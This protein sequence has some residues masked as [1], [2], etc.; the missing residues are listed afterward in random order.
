MTQIKNKHGKIVINL[1]YQDGQMA[2]LLTVM[3]DELS[4]YV[5]AKVG[6]PTSLDDPRRQDISTFYGDNAGEQAQGALGT[7]CVGAEAFQNGLKG[8]DF[9]AVNDEVANT[10][11]MEKRTVE[12]MIRDVYSRDFGNTPEQRLD[13]FKHDVLVP[14]AE[15]PATKVGGVLVTELTPAGDIS[16]IGLGT[17]PYTGEKLTLKE[18]KK[19]LAQTVALNY[20]GKI[21]KT[22]K[23][24]QQVIK[25]KVLALQ[26]RLGGAY[27]PAQDI[28]S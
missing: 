25:P 6:R 28:K 8:L 17:D 19:E 22:S 15:H 1:A 2:T 3:G 23:A 4:H 21:L 13:D 24:I 11:G 9:Q 18:R 10:E 7:E 20:G 16:R 26:D 27:H 12:D 5:D 14:I